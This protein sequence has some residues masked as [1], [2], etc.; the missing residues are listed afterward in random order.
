MIG[1]CALTLYC[2]LTF[3]LLLLHSYFSLTFTTFLQ[4]TN[5]HFLLLAYKLIEKHFAYIIL[6]H[7]ISCSLCLTSITKT[8]IYCLFINLLQ[9]TYYFITFL[10]FVMNGVLT[11]TKLLFLAA[12]IFLHLLL[13]PIYYNKLYSYKNA[14]HTTLLHN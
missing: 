3:H 11:F 14:L 2:I 10:L 8:F 4:P 12:F 7:N 5:K 6:L 13:F 9:Y 1:F